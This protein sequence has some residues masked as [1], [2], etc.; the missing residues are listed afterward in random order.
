MFRHSILANKNKSVGSKNVDNTIGLD[1][2]RTTRQ[3]THNDVV[4]TLDVNEQ[5]LNERNACKDF[6]LTLTVNPFCSNELFNA[7]TEII[8]QEGSEDC[9]AVVNDNGITLSQYQSRIN[10]NKVICK[11]T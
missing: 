1:I 6:R 9:Q 2:Q 10:N 3:F 4:G 5:Y 8:W 11:N 7:C